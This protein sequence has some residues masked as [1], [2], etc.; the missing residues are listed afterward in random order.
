[1]GYTHYWEL[2]RK[3]SDEKWNEIVSDCKTLSELLP[4]HSTSS[5]GLFKDEPLQLDDN[6]YFGKFIQFNGIENLGHEDFFF[7]NT[8]T[9]GFCKTNR[10]PYDLMVQI[11]ILTFVHHLGDDLIKTSSDGESDDWEESRKIVTNY[12][13]KKESQ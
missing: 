10:K 9:A 1:M 4:K 6:S 8:P 12:F 7:T 3:L 11:C 2:K 5:G 13:K